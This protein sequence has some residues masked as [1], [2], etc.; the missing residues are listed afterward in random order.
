M[1]VP[2]SDSP[3]KKLEEGREHN[4]ITKLAENTPRYGKTKTYFNKPSKRLKRTPVRDQENG[5]PFESVLIIPEILKFYFDI[6]CADVVYLL[7]EKL[8]LL[9]HFFSN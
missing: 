4:K 3:A 2:P 9:T 6:I 1:R 8:S 5:F 7:G